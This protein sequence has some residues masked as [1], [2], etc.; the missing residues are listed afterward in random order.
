MKQLINC[1]KLCL[2]LICVQ[3]LFNA[4]AYEVIYAVNVGGDAFNDSEGISYEPDENKVGSKYKTSILNLTSAPEADRLLYETR[5]TSSILP[6]GYDMPVP[7]DGHYVLIIKMG[8]STES[9]G[10][11]VFNAYLN[12]NHTILSNFDQVKIAGGYPA[13]DEYIYFTICRRTLMNGNQMSKVN[14]NK[15]RVEFKPVTNYPSISAILLI[16]GRIGEKK[17][18]S[19]SNSNATMFFDPKHTPCQEDETTNVDKPTKFVEFIKQQLSEMPE[20][21]RKKFSPYFLFNI[22]IH[23]NYKKNEDMTFSGSDQVNQ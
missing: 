15:I 11:T 14:D 2:I 3:Y 21:N 9:V 8:I 1:V 22:N 16:K 18:L 13:H 7:E 19:S 17:K 6:F 10:F 5:R 12:D 20:E 23:N 4:K